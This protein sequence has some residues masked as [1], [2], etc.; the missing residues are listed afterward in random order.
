MGITTSMRFI[1]KLYDE[2]AI[3]FNIDRDYDVTLCKNQNDF[4]RKYNSNL[5]SHPWN[6][7]ELLITKLSLVILEN[8]RCYMYPV[9]DIEAVM[10]NDTVYE[11]EHDDDKYTEL[12][13]LYN[14]IETELILDNV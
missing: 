8:D 6:S 1:V 12:E 9:E 11:F 14:N 13:S 5:L 2:T 7:T 4:D 3:D 10:F